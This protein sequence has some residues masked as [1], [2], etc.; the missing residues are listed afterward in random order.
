M[1]QEKKYTFSLGN[2]SNVR[3]SIQDSKYAISKSYN[4]RYVN[5]IY[6]D[7]FNSLNYEE[8][9]TGLSKRSK[10]RLRW[11]SDSPFSKIS[12]S[13]DIFFE[14]K[15]RTNLFG[16]KLI[17]KI[18]FPDDLFYCDSIS[19]MNY[20]RQTLPVTFLPYIDHCS[21]FSLGVSYEREYYETF[22]K[23]IRATI[24]NNIKFARLNSF[25][26]L[27]FKQLET[28]KVEY[29]ILELK[30]PQNIY[31]E[32]SNIKFDGVEITSG[33]H[34]KYTVGLNLINK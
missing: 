29:G 15:I 6:L 26:V 12:R 25:E 30:F 9:L 20:L 27:N 28:Y 33:R 8:N 2:L 32:I 10:A 18:N 21:I 16:D 5:S 13:T 31:N 3:K 24:D 22:T 17:H 23:K 11:Y 1:R 7:S 19:M 14:I 4:N 34:S